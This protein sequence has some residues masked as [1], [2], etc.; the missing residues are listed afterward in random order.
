MKCL[1]NH[2]CASEFS[3]ESI[4]LQDGSVSGEDACYFRIVVSGLLMPDR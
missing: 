3:V 4:F 2:D 1:Y